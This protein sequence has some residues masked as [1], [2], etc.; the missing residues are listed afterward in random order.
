MELIESTIINVFIFNYWFSLYY[1]CTRKRFWWWVFRIW[2]FSLKH[3]HEDLYALLI[4]SVFSPFL[5]MLL[6]QHFLNNERGRKE[7][8]FWRVEGTRFCIWQMQQ[9]CLDQKM[10]GVHLWTYP[11]PVGP[12][13][14]VIEIFPVP[15]RFSWSLYSSLVGQ[16]VKNIPKYIK[17]KLEW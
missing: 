17:V 9:Y 11:W 13:I 5:A 6:S 8:I 14:A 12:W 10:N 15:G 2:L 1:I 3:K 7:G 4:F 16:T